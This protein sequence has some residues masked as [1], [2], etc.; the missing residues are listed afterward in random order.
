MIRSLSTRASCSAFATSSSTSTTR[1]AADVSVRSC[2]LVDLALR[3]PQQGGRPFLGLDDDP[4]R[5]LVGVAEDLG[6]VLAQRSRQRGFVHHR[7]GGPLLRLG[8]GGPQL[9]LACLERFEAAGDRLQIGTDLVAVEAPA[10]H[11]EGMLGDVAGCD[12]GR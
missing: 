10:D 12:P 7:V 2:K 11:G 3:L 6:T 1:S 9:L 5:F 8:Q 4:G